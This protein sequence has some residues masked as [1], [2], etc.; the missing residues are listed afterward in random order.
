MSPQT[1][2]P[3]PLSGP[4]KLM[5]KLQ[6]IVLG[7]ICCL[8]AFAQ[9]QIDVTGNVSFQDAG[10]P[11]VS[12]TV[13]GTTL[14]TS[15]DPEGN[16]LL[17]GVSPDAVLVFSL[18]GFGQQE[19]P[20]DGRT[21]IDVTMAE[22]V[23]SLDQVVVIGYGTARKVDLTGAVSQVNAEKL[24]NENP[25]AVADIL[26]GNIAGLNVGFSTS[27]KGG[28]GLLVRGRGTLNANSSPL[29]VVDGVI[30]PGQL[31]DIN[32]NDIENI[33]VLKDA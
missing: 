3:G 16:Y 30:Y 20:V 2:P 18:L 5:L 26:R 11:G 25:N 31:A 19:I 27:A 28:A 14:G 7:V 6:S 33:H 15:T 13:K 23:A 22:D 9:D 24:E 4:R 8:P 10:L 29:I 32:P 1:H 21:T 12:I 17:E